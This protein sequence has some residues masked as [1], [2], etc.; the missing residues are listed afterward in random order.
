MI[1]SIRP[2]VVELLGQLGSSREARQY[3]EQFSQ[4]NESHFAVIKVG[5]GILAEQLDE[6]A[7][8]LGFLHRLGL[9]PIVLHGAGQQLDQALEEA[10]IAT[11]KHDGLRVTTED[12]MAVARPVIYRENA[13]LVDRLE[14]HGVRARGLLHGIFECD[15]EDRD[16]LGLVGQVKQ[17]ELT[18]IRTAVEAGM[19]PVVACLGETRAGQVLNI[20]AD[21]AT[22]EL[23]WKIEPYKIIFLTPTGGLLD[24][25]GRIISSI[26][27]SSDYDD[28]LARDWVHS[29][30]RLKLQQIRDMLEPLPP[31]ASVSITSAVKLTRELFTHSGAG[32][33]LRKGEQI[34]WLEDIPESRRAAL[35]QLIEA[36]FGRQLQPDWLQGRQLHGLLIAQSN[37]AAA[38]VLRGHDGVPY[39]DKLAVT[40]E[41]RGE[42]LGASLWQALISRCPQLYWRSRVNNPISNWYFQHAD[43]SH[44]QGEWVVF[45]N[46]C[47]DF[48]QLDALTRDALQRDPGW[49]PEQAAG[50][51]VS[52]GRIGEPA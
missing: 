20:N 2:I 5:G 44:R 4:V 22:R 26:S 6:L 35:E 43:I 23:V 19:L 18:P 50:A 17:I 31:A 1:N 52:S 34:D 38:V 10:G 30:M 33:L 14:Q 27:L 28:L 9:Y 24:D 13:R 12:V 32:T 37:R 15:F 48:P 21:I 3:L 39:L 36:S 11:V 41:A 16:R 46:G 45:V 25:S 8:A 49:L 29:G 40:P 42:G 51:Q 7:A 47:A